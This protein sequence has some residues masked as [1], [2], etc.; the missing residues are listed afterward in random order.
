MTKRPNPIEHEI[1]RVAARAT[2]ADA[3][4]SYVLDAEVRWRMPGGIYGLFQEME[5]KD[6]HLFATLQT[7]RNALAACPWRVV[8][9]ERGAGEAPLGGRAPRSRHAASPAM[10]GGTAGPHTRAE[11]RQEVARFLEETLCE[12]P[13][14]HEAIHH[15][16][17]AFGKGFAVLEII[18]RRDE[19]GNRV[20][21]ERLAPRWPGY[22][23]Q[24][25]V[26]QWFLLDPEPQSAMP[27]PHGEQG[28]GRAPA[29]LPRPGEWSAPWGRP[30]AL[31]PR[32]FLFFVFQ[33]HPAAPYGT[34][35]CAKAYWYYWFKKNNLRF[36]SLYNEK[37]GAPTAV[38]RYGAGTT[39]EEIQRLNEVVAQL[40]SDLGVVIPESVSME[41]LEAHR[42][43]AASTY[44]EF[45]DWCNDEISKLVLGQTLT[46]SEGRRSGSLALGRV[47]EAVRYDYLAA[48]ARALGDALTHQLIRWLVDF[49]FGVHVAAPELVFDCEQPQD[50]KAEL[51]LD[52]GLIQLGVPLE[53]DYFYAK[54]RRPAPSAVSR[55]LK[56]DD[57]NLYQYHLQYGVLTVNEV[58]AALG[59][60]PVAWGNRP[61]VRQG[62]AGGTEADAAA[63]K[64]PLVDALEAHKDQLP[65]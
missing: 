6:A 9:R 56:Y 10:A 28:H 22:F 15:L 32:K 27:A 64:E 4:L 65:H 52:R 54:Y 16:L 61:P 53:T 42:S 31:P 59:L 18:W 43:G 1:A 26:G 41:L 60:P 37:F 11:H 47:H 44:R 50:Y 49:N 51:E 35:L 5:E 40:Q 12:I 8:W 30:V 25:D 45:A 33:P 19:Q 21:V 39:P 7:R 24:D 29:L 58:R 17:D 36:W 23:A 2:T 13:N 3:S 62:P 57:A 38:A 14:F 63:Q 55:V 48:D 34:A 20:R 46:T